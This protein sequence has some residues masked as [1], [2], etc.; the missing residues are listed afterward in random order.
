MKLPVPPPTW[1]ELLGLPPGAHDARTAT[2]RMATR[3]A[4]LIPLGLGPTVAGRYRHWNKLRFLAPPKG[5]KAKDWWLALK[6][7][8]APQLRETPLRDVEGRPFKLAM[9]DSALEMIHRVDSRASG[10]LLAAYPT[11]GP[12][13][14]ERYVL[15]S[16]VEEAISSSQLEGAATT[17]R[18]AKEM[19]RS[20]RAPRDRSERMIVNNYQT[21]LWLRERKAEPLTPDLVFEIHRRITEDTLD[22]PDCSGRLRRAD[23]DIVVRDFEKVVHVP[24]PAGQLARRLESMCTFASAQGKAPFVHPVVRA[25]LLH[26]WLAYDHPFVDGNGRTARALFYWS[27]LHQ[28]YWLCEFLPISSTIKR[29]PS[30]YARAFLYTESDENDLTYFVLYH[31]DVICR[32]IDDLHGYLA[33]KQKEQATVLNLVSKSVALNERQIALLTHALAHEDAE[34][35]F[36]GHRRSH[37]VVYQT[38]RADL[39]DL[40]ERGLLSQ[41]KVGRTLVFAPRPDLEARIRRLRK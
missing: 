9:V 7:A 21:M 20:G 13:A 4:E 29:A 14:G 10:E 31:L 22:D 5:L 15:S 8:R 35:T 1:N 16:F 41:T 38:A 28:G 34:Y 6:L 36:E 3:W 23:E 12:G 27:M 24:P 2:D 18:V 30:R 37:G 11:I 32:A 33:E 39:L 40:A 25:V 17:R 19:I 26:F